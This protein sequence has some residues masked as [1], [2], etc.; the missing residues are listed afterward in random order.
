MTHPASAC[1][2]VDLF[3]GPG[4][5]SQACKLLGLAEVGVELDPAV[6]ATRTA[7]GHATVRADVAS[8]PVAHLKGRIRGLIASPPCQGF[9]AAGHRNGLSDLD[10]CHDVLDDIS[11]GQ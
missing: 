3:A 9:S 10:L 4:G 5:W 7:A 6:C 1:T 11:Q 8:L 2:D